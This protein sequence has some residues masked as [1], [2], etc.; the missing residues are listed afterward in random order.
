M[1]TKLFCF[2]KNLLL[3]LRAFALNLEE[4]WLLVVRPTNTVDSADVSGKVDV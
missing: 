2:A 3:G 4:S 1:G